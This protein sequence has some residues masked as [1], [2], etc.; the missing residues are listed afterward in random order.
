MNI[1]T[2]LI[3]GIT[4]FTQTTF[5]QQ[6]HIGLEAGIN[7]STLHF[8]P[9]ASAF[10]TN[11]KVSNKPGVKL[12]LIAD[13]RITDHICIQTGAYYSMKGVKLTGNELELRYTYHYLEIPVLFKYCF[14]NIFIAAG[15]YIGPVFNGKV[16]LISVDTNLTEKIPIG[17]NPATDG[18]QRLDAGINLKAGYALPA[19]LFFSM[20]YGFGF[21]NISPAAN[22][23][24]NHRVFNL[25]IG[26]FFGKH[27]KPTH[28]PPIKK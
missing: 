7:I 27:T 24:E 8:S 13:L 4:A 18:I 10:S 17:N 16:K 28:D 2:V 20:Q 1:K 23:T 19:G 6:S 11:V 12:G 22:T 3:C 15:P 25:S 14:K 21:A 9:P 26:Y 5:A